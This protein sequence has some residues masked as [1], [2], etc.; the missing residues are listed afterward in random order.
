[1]DKKQINIIQ[2]ICVSHLRADPGVVNIYVVNSPHIKLI[3]ITE[4]VANYPNEV[5]PF[6]LNYFPDFDFNINYSIILLSE[7]EWQMIRR[8]ELN[9]PD[10][11][12]NY[13]H[14]RKLR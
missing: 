6:N 13:I 14:Y 1:M 12:K 3:E 11:W 10:D 7:K 5:V 8:D 4:S 2:R 9:L